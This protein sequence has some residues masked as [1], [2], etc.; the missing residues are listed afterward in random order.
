MDW[1]LVDVSAHCQNP[2]TRGSEKKSDGSSVCSLKMFKF[3]LEDF[4]RL[5]SK[6]LVSCTKWR[7]SLAAITRITLK[8]KMFL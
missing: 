6:N 4:N 5:H 7:I 1:N 8:D 3:S 2:V